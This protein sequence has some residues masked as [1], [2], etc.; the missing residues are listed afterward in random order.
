MVTKAYFSVRVYKNTLS[1]E[2]RKAIAHAILVFNR[3]RRIAFSTSVK[4]KRSGKSKRSKSMH[5][6]V[7]DLFSLDDYYANSAVQEANAIQQSLI[8]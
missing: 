4:E 3:A 6:K 1:K 5:L 2:Y 7:K 8:K